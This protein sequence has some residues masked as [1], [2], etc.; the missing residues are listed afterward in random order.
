MS[1]KVFA[2]GNTLRVI[3]CSGDMPQGREIELF[4]SEEIE[5]LA[6]QRI[7]QS[8]PKKSREDMMF[9]TQ[10]KSPQAWMKEDE[11]DVA[12]ESLPS[13]ASLPLAEFKA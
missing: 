7:W 3:D 9:Q 13:N 12:I 5:K 11:W 8:I 6:A 10:S 2:E 4:T 1:V